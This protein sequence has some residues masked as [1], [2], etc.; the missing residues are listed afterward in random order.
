MKIRIGTQLQMVPTINIYKNQSNDTKKLPCTVVYINREHRF[1]TVEYK[2]L[3]GSF[4]E[5]YKF[6]ERGDL[7]CLNQ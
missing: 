3:Y 4:R 1:F 7:V 2:F 6:Y 5:S